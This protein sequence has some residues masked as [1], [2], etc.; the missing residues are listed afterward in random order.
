MAAKHIPLIALTILAVGHVWLDI[1]L[2][3]AAREVALRRER[4]LSSYSQSVNSRLGSKSHVLRT[5]F[6]GDD[7]PLLFPAKGAKQGLRMS[8]EESVHYTLLDPQSPDEWL[9]ISSVGDGHLRLGP[10]YRMFG[11]GFT[12]Q[13][14]CLQYLIAMLRNQHPVHGAQK[15]HTEHCLNHIRQ[16]VLC[17]ADITLEPADVFSRNW[18]TERWI[19]EHQCVDWKTVMAEFEESWLDWEG[20]KNEITSQPGVIVV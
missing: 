14:H 3:N 8:V 17:D 19:G 9:Y 12:H 18:T 16:Y 11:V 6:L 20:M 7:Y 10:G 15:I 2:S 4:P 5:A 1:L 13:Q